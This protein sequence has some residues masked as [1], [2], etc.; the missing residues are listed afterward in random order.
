MGVKIRR[1]LPK[2]ADLQVGPEFWY[3]TRAARTG[4]STPRFS[5]AGVVG[6]ARE[7]S[8][9]D[10]A[11]GSL[12][13]E[14]ELSA[15]TQGRGPLRSLQ[16]HVST[17]RAWRLSV[18]PGAD[19]RLGHLQRVQASP[20]SR[21]LSAK[22]GAAGHS[23]GQSLRTVSKPNSSSEG[24]TARPVRHMLEQARTRG[25]AAAA[26]CLSLRAGGSFPLLASAGGRRHGGR[27]A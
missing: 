19:P 18:G 17:T 13:G 8:D 16:V 7:G 9:G 1:A 15:R 24:Y 11:M 22:I 25:T 6:S 3:P 26:P 20:L 27:R 21:V 2:N 5:E 10:E 14:R 4:S 12:E 23:A